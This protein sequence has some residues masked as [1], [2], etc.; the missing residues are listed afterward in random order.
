MKAEQIGKALAWSRIITFPFM[1]ILFFSV[2]RLIC[3]FVYLIMFSTDALDG[4]FARLMGK[5]GI[6]RRRL[7]SYGDVLYLIAGLV[8]FAYLETDFFLQHL[9]LII[10]LLL[11]YAIQLVVALIKWRRPTSFH[12]IVARAAAFVQ[13]GFFTFSFFFGVWEPLFW[14]TI[15]ITLL[16]IADELSLTFLLKDY[17]TGINSVLLHDRHKKRQK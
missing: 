5:D 8:G 16:D 7:D 17:Q 14:I 1:I 12:T 11:L 15:V 9:W 2:S 10:F 4:F 13:A 3:G 6:E